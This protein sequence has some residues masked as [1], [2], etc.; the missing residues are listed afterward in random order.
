MRPQM[1]VTTPVVGL[2]ALLLQW[3]GIAAG[4]GVTCSKEVELVVGVEGDLA[5]LDGSLVQNDAGQ[6]F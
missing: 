1:R 4:A 3:E 5:A 2:V 6:E